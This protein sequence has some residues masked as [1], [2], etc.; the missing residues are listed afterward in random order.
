MIAP[1]T[2]VRLLKVPLEINDLNQLTFANATAQYNYFNGLPKIIFEDNFTYQRKDGILRVPAL[3]D[4]IMNYNYVMYRNEAYS[5]KWFYAFIE[6]MEWLNDNVTLIK[7]K[8]DVWQC[9]QFELSYKPTFIEREH[10]NDDTIGLNTQPEGLETGSLIVNGNII[11]ITPVTDVTPPSGG[12]YITFMVS[13]RTL[14]PLT[15]QNISSQ[16]N[17]IF[18]GYTLF[19][20]ETVA[21]A[22]AVVKEFVDPTGTEGSYADA[23]KSIFLVPKSLYGTSTSYQGD[24]FAFSLIVPQDAVQPISLVASKTIDRLPTLNGYQPKNNKLF[25][26][27]FS[28]LF[29]SNNVGGNAEYRY[30]D[31]KDATP[32]FSLDGIISSGCDIKLNPLYYKNINAANQAYGLKLSKLPV[33]SWNTDSYAIWL[34]QNQLN[35]RVSLTRN[36]LKTAA[37]VI[38]QNPELIGGGI[39]S[40]AGDL[41]NSMSEKYIAERTPDEVHGDVN[42]SDYNFSANLFFSVRRM[43]LRAEYARNID[44]YFSAVGYATNK[45]KVPN[46]TG[47]R[48][49]NYVKTADCYIEGD[50]PQGDLNEIKSMFNKGITLWHNPATFADYSQNNDII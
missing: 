30:E 46:I 10:T 38:T 40:Y 20:V 43:S 25:T 32:K 31:F 47:R 24:R 45:I 3:I 7:L 42:S 50:I 1:Q 19:G 39:G 29:V 22:S 15:M 8:S 26:W 16:Y 5:D 33:C 4:D 9:W 36:T 12:W 48:N 18:S 6:N 17:G 27:P 2:E 13:D 35:M 37:G 28:Y 44:D 21:Q 11:G 41:L 34:A 23:I 14:L 49:W